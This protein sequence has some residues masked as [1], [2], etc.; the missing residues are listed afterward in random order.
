MITTGDYRHFT[1]LHYAA[2]SGSENNTSLLLAN[3]ADPNAFGHRLKTPLHKARSPKVVK[4]LLHNGGDPYLKLKEK[5][6][7]EK[8]Y[9]SNCEC[10]NESPCEKGVYSVFSTLLHRN[11]KSAEV[12]LDEFITTNEQPID[13]SDLLMVYDLELFKHEAQHINEEP[14]EMSGHSQ[15]VGLKSPILSHPLSQVMLNLKWGCLSKLF[16][17]TVLQYVFFVLAL[18]ALAI[19]QTYLVKVYEERNQTIKE[20]CLKNTSDEECYFTRV[21]DAL[22]TTET[23]HFATFFVL[24]LISCINTAYLFFREF[25]QLIYNWRHYSKSNEDKME[26]ILIIFTIILTMRKGHFNISIL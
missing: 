13:S 16:W 8:C 5:L 26:A 11:D 15:I 10:C 19:Y 6:E 7:G 21:L 23:P 4:M 2:K 17:V 22:A 20:T 18:S 12:L 9:N 3:G 25:S 24:Y 1:P 14:D